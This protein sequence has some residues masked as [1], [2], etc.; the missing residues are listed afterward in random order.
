[1]RNCIFKSSID[2]YDTILRHKVTY[3]SLFFNF[4]TANNTISDALYL[5]KNVSSL[6]EYRFS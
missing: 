1:M 4:L 3:K 2:S 6:I 5:L